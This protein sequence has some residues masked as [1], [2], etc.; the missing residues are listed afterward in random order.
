MNIAGCN[1][2]GYVAKAVLAEAKRQHKDL[3]AL[4]YDIQTAFPRVDYRYLAKIQRA[5]GYPEEYIQMSADLYNGSSFTV[6]NG[7]GEETAPV[8]SGNGLKEGDPISP[9]HF[10]IAVEPLMQVLKRYSETYGVTI[11]N[12]CL[13]HTAYADDLK[14]FADT[15]EKATFLHRL[16]L[17]FYKWAGMTPNASKSAILAIQHKNGHCQIDEE[18]R[19]KIRGQQIPKISYEESYR[20]L[21]VED[22]ATGERP[23]IQ[24]SEVVQQC[25]PYLHAIFESNLHPAQKVRAVKMHVLSKFDFIARNTQ[26]KARDLKVFDNLVRKLIKNDM[27]LPKT[28]TN[29]LLYAA[30]SAGGLEMTKLTDKVRATQI[31]HALQLLESKDPSV[32]AIARYQAIETVKRRYIVPTDATNEQEW[33]YIIALF[34]GTLDKILTSK[35]HSGGDIQTLWSVIYHTQKFDKLGSYRLSM[36]DHTGATSVGLEDVNKKPRED[37]IPLPLVNK[38]EYVKT[39]RLQI[40]RRHAKAWSEKRDQGK[41][42]RYF[43]GLASR[44]V[45]DPKYLNAIDYGFM[46][47]ARVNKVMTNQQLC[48]LKRQT[49][50]Q[51]RHCGQLETLPHVLNHCKHNMEAITSRH[52]SIQNRW[53]KAI[54]FAEERRQRLDKNAPKAVIT[55]D[56]KPP[57]ASAI[58]RPDITVEYPEQKV[59]HIIDVAVTF[60]D[61][62]NEAMEKR[63]LE[64]ENKYTSTIAAPYRQR[65][66]KVE[67]HALIYGSLGAIDPKNKGLATTLDLN[68]KFIRKMEIYCSLDA[69]QASSKIWWAHKNK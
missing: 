66:Y 19:L 4:F 34:N 13:N 49:N 28:A 60:E 42:A 7:K 23:K 68:P 14:V 2:H 33:E 1:E 38:K 9:I 24:V 3:Y 40:S 25:K 53:V 32:A 63:R 47:R 10:N 20:Y 6:V 12:I 15:P 61:A 36:S 35:H 21:G 59:I 67:Q 56:H 57:Y 64:K 8:Y 48:K 5:M 46:M 54:K 29:D 43:K 31:A 45:R 52:N 69:I 62:R 37:N 22:G 11:D 39:L 41:G 18:F 58:V 50:A 30:S 26:P 51:C 27:R 16:V 55:I 44:V 65:G 17:R